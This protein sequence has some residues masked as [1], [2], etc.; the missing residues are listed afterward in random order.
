MKIDKALKSVNALITSFVVAGVLIGVLVA[1]Q[2]QSSVAANSYLVDELNAQKELLQSFDDDREALKNRIFDL[3]KQI[4]ENRQTLELSA[5]KVSLDKLDTLKTQAGFNKLRGKGVRILL[6]EGK[7]QNAQ[8]D[9]NLVHA[10]D[11]RDLVNLLRTASVEGISINEQR[12]IPGSTINALG[13]D[14]LVNRVKTASPFEI[15]VVGDV[16]LITNRLSDQSAYPDLYRRIK[17]KDVN[18]EMEKLEQ[19]NLPAYDGDFSI[20]YATDVK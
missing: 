1:A 8:S 5:E 4:E 10:A 16:N 19:V 18:M 6:A 15:N 2:F 12:I 3:R 7:A 11:L 9:S 17:N 14:V 13:S 20:K